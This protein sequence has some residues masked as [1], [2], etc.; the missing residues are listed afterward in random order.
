MIY[1]KWQMVLEYVEVGGIKL[2]IN[3]EYQTLSPQKN[4]KL[5]L[6]YDYNLNYK[7]VQ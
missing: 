4:R 7:S 3:S 2:N 6:L 1:L 5:L